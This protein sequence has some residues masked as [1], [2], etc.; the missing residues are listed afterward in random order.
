MTKSKI[1]VKKLIFLKT[2]IKYPRISARK[3]AKISGLS[4]P[5]IKKNIKASGDDKLT[6][7]GYTHFNIILL[8]VSQKKEAV[9]FLKN[10]PNIQI[11]LG[12]NNWNIVL[13]VYTK[14]LKDFDLLLRDILFNLKEIKAIISQWHVIKDLKYFSS[15]DK[16][17]IELIDSE[18]NSIDAL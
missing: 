4:Q 15:S 17:L 11:I 2:I 13:H 5:F 7:L 8:K 12:K 18:I 1:R 3:L 6:Y 9:E 10:K 14:T 16:F